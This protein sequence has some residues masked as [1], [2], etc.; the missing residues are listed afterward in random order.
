ME[1]PTLV[2]LMGIPASGKSSFYRRYLADRFVRVNLDTLKTRARERQLVEDC[3][4]QGK[5]F[6][7]DNTNP[8]RADRARYIG[9]AKA[10]GYRVVGYF[11]QS[12]IAD[13]VARN[14]LRTG[15]ERIPDTAVAAIANRLEFPARGEGFDALYFVSP[16]KDEMRIEVWRE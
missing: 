3:I 10:A 4:R 1:R 5:S 6:A 2:I 9:P 11:M 7:V 16:E 12:R 8:T 14:R 13:C 15:K